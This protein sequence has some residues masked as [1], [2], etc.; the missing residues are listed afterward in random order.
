M[1]MKKS[2]IYGFS[3][4]D[5]EGLG[6]TRYFNGSDSIISDNPEGNLPFGLR[7]IYVAQLF[8]GFHPA[9]SLSESL[10]KRSEELTFKIITYEDWKKIEHPVKR[11][12]KNLFKKSS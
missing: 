11:F 6:F 2:D 9:R 5:N 1:A 10:A 12:F 3:V 8:L 7:K 4:T